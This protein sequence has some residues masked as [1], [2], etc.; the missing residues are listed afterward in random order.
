MIA[1]SEK[2]KPWIPKIFSEKNAKAGISVRV[3]FMCEKSS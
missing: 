3:V 1:M 2:M